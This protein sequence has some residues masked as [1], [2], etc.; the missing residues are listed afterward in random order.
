MP[1][2]EDV[3]GGPPD[4]PRRLADGG[5]LFT[6]CRP[7]SCTE[8]GA[9]AFDAHGRIVV[10]S[11]VSYR[12]GAGS[13]C[14]SSPSLDHYVR[15]PAASAVAR[16]AIHAWAQVQTAADNGQSSGGPLGSPIVHVLR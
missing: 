14:A 5:L 3:L 12:C 6:A 7:H 1:Q 4:E 13:H 8:K 15:D 11:I 2:I 16:A 9:V 10:A